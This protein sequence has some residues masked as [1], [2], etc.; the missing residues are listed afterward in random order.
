MCLT[1]TVFPDPVGPQAFYD[2]YEKRS[3]CLVKQPQK[4]QIVAVLLTDRLVNLDNMPSLVVD[5]N[6]RRQA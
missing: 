4:S 6:A 2:N 1:H 3:E 5:L